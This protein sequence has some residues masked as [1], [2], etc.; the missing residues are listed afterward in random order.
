[1]SADRDQ[2]E[3]IARK[4]NVDV[5][6]GWEAGIQGKRRVNGRLE[7][8]TPPEHLSGPRIVDWHLGREAAAKLLSTRLT[9]FTAKTPDGQD[10]T[11]RRRGWVSRWPVV[12]AIGKKGACGEVRVYYMEESEIVKQ[13]NCLL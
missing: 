9:I 7:D 5:I 13:H 3:R 6:S 1:M 10:L 4:I 11:I 12:M 8:R 2:V